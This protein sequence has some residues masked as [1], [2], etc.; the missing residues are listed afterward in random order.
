[1]IKVPSS[2]LHENLGGKVHF[3][4]LDPRRVII[5]VIVAISACGIGVVL[6][7]VRAAAARCSRAVL[8]FLQPLEG[9]KPREV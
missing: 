5:V 2:L 7:N 3:D 4:L 9:E 8:P 1:V 6:A